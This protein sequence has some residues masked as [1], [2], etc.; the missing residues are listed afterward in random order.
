MVSSL[1]IISCYVIILVIF[2]I[3]SVIESKFIKLSV[4]LM[5]IFTK[6]EP[7]QILKLIDLISKFYSKEL[8]HYLIEKDSNAHEILAIADA[9]E[10]A[11][12]EE[13]E[14]QG[15]EK[16][17]Q[18]QLD[19]RSE[20]IE[21]MMEDTEP[22]IIT[23]RKSKL[24]QLRVN[25]A[26]SSVKYWSSYKAFRKVNFRKMMRVKTIICPLAIL[27]LTFCLVSSTF[28]FTSSK[29]KFLNN[30]CTLQMLFAFSTANIFIMNAALGEMVYS[31]SPTSAFNINFYDKQR[32]F[33]LY[34]TYKF[35]NEIS[36]HNIEGLSEFKTFLN[37]T[38]DT[39]SIFLNMMAREVQRNPLQVA[40]LSNKD[41][42]TLVIDFINNL[43]EIVYSYQNPSTVTPVYVS[44]LEDM[45]FDLTLILDD[46]LTKLND[47]LTANLSRVST[48][49]NLFF[50]LILITFLV[51]TLYFVYYSLLSLQKKIIHELYASKNVLNVIKSSLIQGSSDVLK[52]IHSQLVPELYEN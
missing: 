40:Y 51:I 6:I 42:K 22:Q 47:K 36:Y 17:N 30:S 44:K 9:N 16:T 26:K 25:A 7:Q 32:D 4:K 11:D 35:Y 31:G 48:T 3:L 46:E 20:V 14:N 49:F 19:V 39:E 52:F 23:K 33:F 8:G 27:L 15:A 38:I 1:Y 13:N 24:N 2:V 34:N 5:F 29:V 45:V 41:I 12:K 21:E 37:T 18:L 28:I 10:D 43:D 50:I